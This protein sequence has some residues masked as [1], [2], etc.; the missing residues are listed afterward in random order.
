MRITVFNGLSGL[1]VRG[2]SKVADE[3]ATHLRN[4]GHIVHEVKI[5]IFLYFNNTFLRILVLIFFQQIVCLFVVLKNR[6]QLLI[7]PYN[8]FSVLAS[9]FVRT[10]YFIHDYTPFNRSYWYFRPGTLYQYIMFKL[11]AFLSL[12]EMYHDGLNIETPIFLKRSVQPKVFPCIVDPLDKSNS[13]FF[14]IHIQS[15]LD[16]VESDCLLLSTISGTGWNKDFGGLV[17]NLKFNNRQFILVAFG[18]GEQ[19]VKKDAITMIDGSFSYVFTVG[20]VNEAA[21]SSV[22]SRSNLFLF[23]SLSEG[24]GRPIIEA[25]QLKKL[26]VSVHAPVIDLLSCEALKNIYQYSND[27]N[28]FKSILNEALLSDFIEFSTTYKPGIDHSLDLFL[29]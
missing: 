17:E 11:D 20:F 8:G 6:S 9:L 7:D 27:R 1:Q 16:I 12:A 4:E 29:G 21:I 15:T 10:K 5:P 2:I 19:G 3:L 22:I 18:F 25:L 28:H 14:D 13:D 24:F 23:H 26:V